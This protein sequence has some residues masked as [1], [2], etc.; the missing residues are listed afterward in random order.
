MRNSAPC[1]SERRA[2]N[3]LAVHRGTLRS[4][5]RVTPLC[6][7]LALAACG[8]TAAPVSTGSPAV[9]AAKPAAS[10]SWSPELRQVIDAANKEG[11]LQLVWSESTFGGSQGA[12]MIESAMNKMFGTNIKIQF[13]PGEAQPQVA[14]KIILEYKAGEKAVSDVYV[15]TATNFVPL[16]GDGA[17]LTIDWPKLLP[18]RI[19][20]E[21]SEQNQAL[22]VITG[23]TGVTYNPK[24]IPS[25]PKTMAD[26]LKPEW[27]GKLATTPAGS[28]FDSLAAKEVWGPEKV[29]D[30]MRQF[31]NQVAGIIRC[32]ETQRIAS[33]EFPALVLDCTGSEAL[34]WQEK[35]APVDF[36]IPLDAAQIRYTYLAVPKNATHPAAATLF[37]VFML[38][39]Q[40]QDISWQTWRADLHLMPES[41][42]KARVDDYQKQGAKF[43]VLT[44]P[45]TIAHPELNDI[46]D[47][48]SKLVAKAGR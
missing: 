14:N 17:L 9:S 10:S 30:Y 27:K 4:T 31:A 43:F 39:A 13:Q 41:H 38:T 25:Q 45:Y 16:E 19:T 32:G 1:H 23:L 24:A 2:K 47:Q 28:G 48:I 22:A 11:A 20:P 15:G 42:T 6:L 26:F 12:A 21:M 35:G 5:L 29:M 37:T 7:V 33:G 46:R 40:G 36:M 18:D 34:V 44:T 3:P 8:G